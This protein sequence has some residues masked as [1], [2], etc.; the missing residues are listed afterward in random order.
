MAELSQLNISS[1]DLQQQKFQHISLCY[2]NQTE[3]KQLIGLDFSLDDN[4]HK[5]FGSCSENLKVEN[6]FPQHLFGYVRGK[7]KKYLQGIYFVWFKICSFNKLPSSCIRRS[8][9]VL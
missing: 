7:T 3:E 9:N 6:A 1:F 8:S 5:Y 2:T 4:T